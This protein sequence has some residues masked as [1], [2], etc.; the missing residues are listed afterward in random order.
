[1]LFLIGLCAF[2][3]PSLQGEPAPY[4]SN[5]SDLIFAFL[6]TLLALGFVC[7]AAYVLLR[8]ILPRFQRQ[9]SPYSLI[10][11]A[12]AASLEPNKTLYVVEVAGKWMTVAA[13]P[14]GVQ[15]LG[16]L[17]A[18]AVKRALAERAAAPLPT[19]PLNGALNAFAENLVR[20]VGK[21]R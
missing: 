1:M 10:H 12:D 8:W 18:D 17:D 21:R 19:P 6:Q 5:D 11:I 3:E 7:A 20:L 4:A 15:L 2:F 16:E 9:K 14:A 13:S